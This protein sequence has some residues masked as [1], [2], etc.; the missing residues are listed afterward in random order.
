ML[1]RRR[2]PHSPPLRRRPLRLPFDRALGGWALAAATLLPLR[3]LAQPLPPVCAGMQT[4][5]AATGAM[6]QFVVPAGI[7]AVAIDAAGA[8]GGAG[9]LNRAG[10]GGARLVAT[11]PVTPGETLNVVVGG[12][13]DSTGLDG[14]GGGGSFVYRTADAP[15]LLLA[16]AGGGGAG[17][18]STGFPG[19]ATSTAT[20]GGG[21]DGGAGASGG[22]GG[23][24]GLIVDS[25]AGGGGLL[26]DGGGGS[27]VAHGGKAL[28]N[29][30]AGG[31]GDPNGGFGGGGGAADGGGGGGGYNGGGGGSGGAADIDGGG[32][33]GSFVNA[34]GT[35][36]FS[37]SGVQGG[38]GQVTFCYAPAQIV[39]VPALSGP[40]AARSTKP[41]WRCALAAPPGK[42]AGCCTYGAYTKGGVSRPAPKC[43]TSPTM[44][45]ICRGRNSSTG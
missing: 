21:P 32:G 43:L 42:A 23:G 24:G 10:G 31:M 44:P 40:A 8:A 16:S 38:N 13:G 45:T 6:Q 22:N 29:G 25:G 33:A 27:F 7:T 18:S 1:Q 3:V 36:L 2:I 19:N 20:S 4:S 30:A 17:I 9:N 28:A 14:G 11:F 5:F 37:Q 34:Q 35:V 26:T 15:G 12:M 41:L 39:E